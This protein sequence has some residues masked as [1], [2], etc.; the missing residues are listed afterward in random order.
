MKNEKILPKEAGLGETKLLIISFSWG[1]GVL[2]SQPILPNFIKYISV[3]AD[4]TGVFTLK[5]K[6]FIRIKRVPGLPLKPQ[7]CE[8][9]EELLLGSR[10]PGR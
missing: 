7:Q 9:I 4:A 2:G 6:D 5:S 1:F 8:R 3:K 10:N